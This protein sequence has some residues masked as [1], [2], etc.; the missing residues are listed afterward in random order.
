MRRRSLAPRVGVI[1]TLL[2]LAL[3]ACSGNT[4]VPD[5]ATTAPANADPATATGAPDDGCELD[6]ASTA[7]GPYT[8]LNQI[9][10]IAAEGAE[11]NE[12]FWSGYPM[13]Q[14]TIEDNQFDPCAELSWIRLS[15]T[16]LADGSEARDASGAVVFFH[17][18]QLLTDPLPVQVAANP[19]VQRLAD[20][21]LEVTFGHYAAPGEAV[22]QELRSIQLTWED[23]QLTLDAAAWYADYSATR[24]RLDL[25]SPPP[26]S[27]APVLPLGNVHQAP[28]DEEFELANY[29][30]SNFRLPLTDDVELR[31]ILRFPAEQSGWGWVGCLGD[32]VNWP[33][34]EPEFGPSPD[35]APMQPAPEGEPN[36]LQISYMPAMMASTAVEREAAA[37]IPFDQTVANESLTRIG[38]YAVDTRGEQVTIS[39]GGTGVTIDHDG[40]E[41]TTV[42][43]INKDRWQVS[44]P[45]P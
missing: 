7:F 39:H 41:T 31:C 14:F 6:L 32:G 36:Y 45:R 11:H 37:E 20:D 28:F 33:V 34:T 21:Q 2:S 9:P 38:H 43:L 19:E 44:D 13:F 29:P 40:F 35:P 10:T 3:V 27:D 18:D 24:T 16:T 17:R 4:A 26:G 42:H 30:G 12:Q 1:A 23:D 5:S 22:T 15:G 25:G 8:A